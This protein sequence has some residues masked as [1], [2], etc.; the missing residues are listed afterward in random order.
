[1]K[2]LGTDALSSVMV[3]GDG[4]LTK[5]FSTPY[6]QYMVRGVDELLAIS[7]LY[8]DKYLPADPGMQTYFYFHQIE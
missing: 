5:T 6:G 8:V 3:Y 2:K 4:L 7:E 1:M